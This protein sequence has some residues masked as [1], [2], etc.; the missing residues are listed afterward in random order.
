M[1]LDGPSRTIEIVPDERPLLVPERE[2][3]EASP[4]SP[5]APAPTRR[6]R[7]PVPA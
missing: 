1:G 4:A 7:E 6:E 3:E 5:P 2:E